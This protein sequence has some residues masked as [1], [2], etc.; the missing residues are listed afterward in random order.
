MLAARR[1]RP[2]EFSD[3]VANNAP[4]ATSAATDAA[5]HFPC[6][7]PRSVFTRQPSGLSAA[8]TLWPLPG[9][10]RTVTTLTDDREHQG[11]RRVQARCPQTHRDGE[12]LRDLSGAL[13]HR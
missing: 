7:R 3:V 6:S 5:R 13:R 11:A 8:P 10:V 4:A 9:A 12:R 1:S 2:L